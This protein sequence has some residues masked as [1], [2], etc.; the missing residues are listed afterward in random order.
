MTRRRCRVFLAGEGPSDIGDLAHEPQ[1]RGDGEGFIQPL[2][3][4]LVDDVEIEF[5]GAK[6][7]FLPGKRA[8]GVIG[9][10]EK[11]RRALALAAA[12][13]ATAVVF[14]KDVDRTAGVKQTERDARRRIDEMRKQ[15]ETGFAAARE[16]SPELSN[17]VA[18]A[19]TPCRMIEAWAL[20]DPEALRTVGAN[21]AEAPEHPELL[22]G[23]ERNPQSNH[24]KRVLERAFGRAANR[25]DFAAIATEADVTTL[26]RRC[27]L[28]FA[29]LAAE[30]R[31]AA[32]RCRTE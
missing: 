3:R 21:P 29:P 26:K 15:I 5:D 20:A 10:G 24:P 25:E 7:A 14:I 30:V 4:K 13:E 8:A 2:L 6:I 12:S 11:A 27:P 17:V 16:K 1:Y 28:S 32:Q 19:A 22:H 18:V 9:H 31:G 23:D